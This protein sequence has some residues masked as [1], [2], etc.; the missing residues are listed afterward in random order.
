MKR[1]LI[2]AGLMALGAAEANA[3]YWGWGAPPPRGPS[4]II[5]PGPGG[6]PPGWRYRTSFDHCESK[7]RQ[8]HE[9]EWRTTQDGRVTKD[10]RRIIYALRSELASKCG[11]G[12]WHPDRGWHHPGRR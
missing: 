3:Q 1:L 6:P 8:L 2:V 9:Y 7:A 11:S 4:V 5:T 12:R 10:E